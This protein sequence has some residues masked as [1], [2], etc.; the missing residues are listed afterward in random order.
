MG[1]MEFNLME[2]NKIIIVICLLFT[3]SFV[4]ASDPT[5]LVSYKKKSKSLLS[6]KEMAEFDALLA[7]LNIGEKDDKREATEEAD[8]APARKRSCHELEKS[9]KRGIKRNVSEDNGEAAVISTA[10]EARKLKRSASTEEAEGA[11]Q[12]KT[13]RL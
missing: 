5:G 13:A 3:I 11:P 7:T 12:R 9:Q 10:Q 6:Q 1:L 2:N 4:Q 8:G